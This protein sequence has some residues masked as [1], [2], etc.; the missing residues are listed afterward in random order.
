MMKLIKISNVSKISLFSFIA[1]VFKTSDSMNLIDYRLGV[2]KRLT[3]ECDRQMCKVLVKP[4][5]FPVNYK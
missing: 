3:V 1:E 4:V 5:N 2:T